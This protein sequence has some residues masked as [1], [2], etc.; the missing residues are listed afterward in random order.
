M[1]L[2]ET[3]RRLGSRLMP[4]HFAAAAVMRDIHSSPVMS[5]H[6]AYMEALRDEVMR[7]RAADPV[8]PALPHSYMTPFLAKKQ[9][10]GSAYRMPR[11]D[12]VRR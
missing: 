2:S 9:R 4:N 7:N 6:T 8:R 11:L 5:A 1:G 10:Q 3:I 12:N